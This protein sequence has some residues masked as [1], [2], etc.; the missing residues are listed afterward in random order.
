MV[1]EDSLKPGKTNTEEDVAQCYSV[2]S[3]Q[4]TRKEEKSI[5]DTHTHGYL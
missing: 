5:V 2:G 4:S 3:I 1:D